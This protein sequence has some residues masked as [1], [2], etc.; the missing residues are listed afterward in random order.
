AAD[1][2]A[3]ARGD[4][5]GDAHHD[6]VRGHLANDD[7]SGPDAAAGTD[8]EGAEDT[9]PGSH[10][11]VVAQ[12]GMALLLLEARAAQC[13]TVQER[14]VLPPLGRLPAHHAHALVT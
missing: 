2:L 12:G 13:H 6:R 11:D 3:I 10:H 14:D 1:A 8:R 4:A 9:G 7:R 5:P